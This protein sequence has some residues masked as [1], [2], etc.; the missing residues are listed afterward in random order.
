M[1]VH[2]RVSGVPLRWLFALLCSV[3]LPL[4]L[5][6]LPVPASE[7]PVSSTVASETVAQLPAST[8]GAKLVAQ[9]ARVRRKGRKGR[10]ELALAIDELLWWKP[11]P[12]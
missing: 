8:L 12:T 10:A 4:L 11:P 5:S 2:A 9:P 7:E 3:L 1:A 6:L